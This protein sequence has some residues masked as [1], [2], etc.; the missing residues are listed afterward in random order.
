MQ[1]YYII[2]SVYTRVYRIPE[3]V[4]RRIC[5]NDGKSYRMKEDK[6]EAKAIVNCGMNLL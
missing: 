2:H 6:K 1:T 5:G 3:R 4:G